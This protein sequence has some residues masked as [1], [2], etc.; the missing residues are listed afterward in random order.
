MAL[1]WMDGFDNYGT[2]TGSNPSPSGVVGRKYIA[3]SQIYLYVETGR[4]AHALRLHNSNGAYIQTPALTTDDTLII[5]LGLK[6]SAV[7]NV[8]LFAFYDGSTKGVNLYLN[9]TGELSVRRGSTVLGT[10][11]GL[12]WTLDTWYWVELKVV[13]HDTTGSYDLKI[14]ESTVLSATGVDTKEGTNN[15]HD[16]IRFSSTTASRIYLDDLYLLDSSGSSNND[17]LGNSKVSTIRPNG[18]DTANW[19]TSTPSANHYENVDEQILD[20]DTSYVEDSTTNTTDLYDYEN[21]SDVDS[22]Y[23]IQ[24][25]TDCRETDATTYALKSVVSSN[26]IQDDG[27]GE[28]VGSISYKTLRRIVEEDPDTN[29]AWSVSGV[30]AALF[31][32]K[33]G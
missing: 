3:V 27:T 15:Y 18:D 8:E 14:A 31:G 28:N 1:L 22:I 13:C 10:T 5:G 26:G 11:S 29:T 6:T 4:F 2:S 23:G 16:R 9:N 32:I 30:N 24:I 7:A 20:D 17:F 12:S 21:L 19:A 33:V 25:N